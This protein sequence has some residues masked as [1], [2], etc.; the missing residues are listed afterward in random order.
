MRKLFII[1]I[2]C[3]GVL[4]AGYAGYRG[5]K[6]WKTKHLVSLGAGF[7]AKS[8]HRNAALSAQE[9][10]RTDPKNLEATRMMAQLA[11]GARSP[12]ALLWLGRVVELA[13]HSLP[14]RLA[15][16]Q[17]ALVMRDYN[18]AINA[19]E[20]VDA[21]DKDT[22]AYHNIAGMVAAATGHPD[23]AERQFQEV[24]RLESQNPAPQL[25][26]AVVRIHRTNATELAEARQVLQRIAVNP[27]NSSLRCQAL[28]ELVL[29]AMGWG[30][31]DTGLALSQQLIRET[32]SSFADRIL[33]LEVLLETKSADFKPTLASFQRDAATNQSEIYEL[34][35]WE[36]AKMS[37]ADALKWLTNLPANLQT[38]QPATLL[39]AECLGSEKK[40][41]EVHAW[42]APQHW[43]DTEFIRHAFMS[44]A[45]REEN[46]PDAGKAEWELALRSANAQKQSLSM[47]LNLAAQWSWI[48]EGEDLLWTMVNRFPEEKWAERALAR[49]LLEGGQTRP[50][51]Q[52]FD[53]E[54][55]RAPSDLAAKNNLASIALLLGAKEVKPNDLALE[56]YQK[57][58]TNAAFAATY[59]FSLYQQGKN[60]EALKVMR[61]V[62][63]KDLEVPAIAGYYGLILKASG[64][65]A[66]ARTYL[67]K[68][69]K[70]RLLPE[71]QRLFSQA[72]AGT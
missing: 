41:K 18:T 24:S 54:L 71:E 20:G 28:R 9:V 22:S 39:I 12:A 59:A 15:L 3:V 57:I 1:V 45:L 60:A 14:D 68:A 44:R 64:D 26:L 13:P 49:T 5:Y 52:L 7:L 72:R 21:A 30:H 35:N 42:L 55:K 37:P 32:N 51:L 63:P 2:S 69:A 67:D 65:M 47:L 27:T 4:L 11:E 6:V 70:I 46:L 48:N 34:G 31:S 53:Q 16:V 40:W 29:D 43:G 66:G 38:N 17:T 33:R 56:V 61:Q 62:N 58:P 23:E 10:L 25:N 36:K 50:L 8:D 19:L